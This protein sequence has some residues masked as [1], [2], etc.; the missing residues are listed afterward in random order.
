M[1]ESCQQ[2]QHTCN[3]PDIIIGIINNFTVLQ[4]E[5]L[6]DSCRRLSTVRQTNV[7]QHNAYQP[8]SVIEEQ[9]TDCDCRKDARGPVSCI[10]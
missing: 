8:T 9:A 4:S 3:Y 6:T 5:D 1:N 10:L 2:S 7:R